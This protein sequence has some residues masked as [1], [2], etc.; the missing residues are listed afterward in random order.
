MVKK[1][2]LIEKILYLKKD[3]IYYEN[4]ETYKADEG[5]YAFI[6][7]VREDSQ[8]LYINMSISDDF[9]F[10]PQL[11]MVNFCILKGDMPIDKALNNFF[12]H[13]SKCTTAEHTFDKWCNHLEKTNQKIEDKKDNVANALLVGSI[14][15]LGLLA[16][17]APIISITGI[18]VSMFAFS[19]FR[20][21][22]KMGVYLKT[23]QREEI[24]QR[25]LSLL[26]SGGNVHSIVLRDSSD[27]PVSIS[28]TEKEPDVFEDEGKDKGETT[29]K[30]TD[31]DNIGDKAT[32]EGCWK[33][34]PK[35]AFTEET[36][37]SFG[38]QLNEG[39][40]EPLMM[41]VWEEYP[42]GLELYR[43]IKPQTDKEKEN[44][45]ENSNNG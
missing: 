31:I 27:N 30:V 37:L 21:R 22:N 9:Y 23:N 11:K 40:A 32:S 19:G 41:G 25:L 2:T 24:L 26:D 36:P 15:T 10:P 28:A 33:T 13:T 17:V 1:D 18:F 20:L 38:E 43:S 29:E 42:M 7:Y 34:K 5:K 4:G 35:D 44:G 39:K 14:V 12:A 8:Y 16:T 3:I 6:N 45:F